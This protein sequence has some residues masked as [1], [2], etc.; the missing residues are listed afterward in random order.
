MPYEAY[1]VMHFLGIFMLITTLAA[2]AMHALRGGN[3][4][5][6]PHRKPIAIAHGLS[7]LLILTGG[8][9][10]LARLGIVQGGLPIWIY[11]KLLIWVALAG[12]IA[13][14]YLGQRY[15][16]WLLGALPVLTAAGGATALYKPF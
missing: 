15:A 5:D 13:V 16:R 1:K 14:P 7:V 11:I 3:R 12:A 2:V 10:L 8:F 6:L 4:Q 9:G